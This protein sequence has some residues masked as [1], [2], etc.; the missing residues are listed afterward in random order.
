MRKYVRCVSEDVFLSLLLVKLERNMLHLLP[1][2]YSAH[3]LA[4]I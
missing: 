4:V 1:H 2:D 3:G